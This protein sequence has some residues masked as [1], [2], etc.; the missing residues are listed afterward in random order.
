MIEVNGSNPLCSTTD[1]PNI[2]WLVGEETPMMR[3]RLNAC[4]NNRDHKRNVLYS[5]AVGIWG[6]GTSLIVMPCEAEQY[7][8]L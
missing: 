1:V 3:S 7:Y 2:H 5:W 6:G 8:Q 4:K